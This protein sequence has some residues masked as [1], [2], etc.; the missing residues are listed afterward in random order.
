MQKVNPLAR[1]VHPLKVEKFVRLAGIIS[2]DTFRYSRNAPREIIRESPRAAAKA[3]VGLSGV[4]RPSLLDRHWITRGAAAPRAHHSS[5]AAPPRGQQVLRPLPG[6][7][8]L[9]DSLPPRMREESLATSMR[10]SACRST[11]TP[12]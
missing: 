12:E 2:R 10:E 7:K 5:R 11:R 9:P 4:A 1:N 3:L 6:P 8:D